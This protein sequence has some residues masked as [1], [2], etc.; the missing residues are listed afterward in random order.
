[1][2]F[3]RIL[4]VGVAASAAPATAAV[5]P[6]TAAVAAA[7]ACTSPAS[8][9]MAT[10]TGETAGVTPSIDGAAPG[11]R[12]VSDASA[13]RGNPTRSPEGVPGQP[14]L[15]ALIDIHGR[16]MLTGHQGPGP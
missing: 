3:P 12:R 10:A 16:S 15:K 4:A 6:A 14:G 2:R 11:S 8:V 9:R 1:M 13:A 7:V 5:A